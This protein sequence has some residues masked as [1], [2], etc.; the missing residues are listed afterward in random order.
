VLA[1]A[2]GAGVRTDEIADERVP[3]PGKVVNGPE[4]P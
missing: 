3:F 2:F 1:R 4:D